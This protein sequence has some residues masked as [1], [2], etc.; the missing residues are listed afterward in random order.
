[1]TGNLSVSPGPGSK[2]FGF[3]MYLV[4]QAAILI[5]ALFLCDI[6]PFK[7]NHG[8]MA[9]PTIAWAINI[10]LI[11]LFGAQH[12]VM[13]RVGFKE[14]VTRLVPAHLERSTFVGI[15]GLVL[16]AMTALWQPLPGAIF[17]LEGMA[18]TTAWVVYG[19]GWAIVVVSTMLIDNKALHGLR[20][21]FSGDAMESS[22]E[23]LTPSLYKL[24][25]HPMM[26]GF[27]IVVWA[28]PD[29]TQGRLLLASA[30]TAYLFVGIHFEEKALVRHFGKAYEDY[31]N[32]VPMVL[33]WP[34]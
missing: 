32:P 24:V 4:S 9:E 11:V 6:G 26:L 25:R 34:R 14:I 10:G 17:Q 20:Q 3:A 16:L 22:G 29:M 21:S 7:I 28:T 2:F 19:F 33:P 27:L 1:M 30:M 8:S 23:L 12:S 13:A 18:R 5:W 15:S 31:K